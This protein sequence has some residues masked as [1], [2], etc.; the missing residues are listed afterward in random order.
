[1]PFLIKRSIS[2]VFEN[3]VAGVI[4]PP[5]TG[6]L[7]LSRSNTNAQLTTIFAVDT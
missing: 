3:A 4:T 6:I 5:L 2:V 7:S 1:M